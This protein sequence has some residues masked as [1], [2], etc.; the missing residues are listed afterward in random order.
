MA[1]KLPGFDASVGT[2]A[3]PAP[4]SSLAPM[5]EPDGAIDGAIG[6]AAGADGTGAEVAGAAPPP[7][8]ESETVQTAAAAKEASFRARMGEPFR[9]MDCCQVVRG[10]RKSGW[11]TFG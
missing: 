6:A 10:C 4:N 8:A 11:D 9:G 1:A 3:Q 5:A 2:A 7:Q